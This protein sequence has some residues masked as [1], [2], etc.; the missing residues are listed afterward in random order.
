MEIMSPLRK[1][2]D[3]AAK[4]A[5]YKHVDKEAGEENGTGSSSPPDT[6][7]EDSL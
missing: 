7:A 3:S 1:T 4:L 2:A 5:K 6:A